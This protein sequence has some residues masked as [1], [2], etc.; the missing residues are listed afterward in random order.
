MAALLAKVRAANGRLFIL[1]VGAVRE[2][3][4]MP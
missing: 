1:G 2:M 3:P 4:P